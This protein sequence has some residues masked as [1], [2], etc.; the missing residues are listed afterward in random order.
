MMKVI[1]AMFAMMIISL[2][3][4]GVMVAASSHG[5][6]GITL[7]ALAGEYNSPDKVKSDSSVQKVSKTSATSNL[8]GGEVAVEG[9]VGL[10]SGTSSYS[11]GSWVTL[12]K[13]DW[14][15]MTNASGQSGTFRLQLQ[16]KKSFVN[17]CTFYGAWWY[18]YTS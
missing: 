17:K 3:F 4:S 9:R 6:T 12:T 15:S 2:I 11:Y 5:F 8:T 7:P 10:K 16:T 13:G 14:T 1:R 18:E